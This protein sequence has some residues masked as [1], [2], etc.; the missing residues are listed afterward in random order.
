MAGGARIDLEVFVNCQ[1]GYHIRC[2]T[3]G[4]T[5]TVTLPDPPQVLVRSAGQERSAVLQDWKLRFNDA[6]DA[7]FVQWVQAVL[8]DELT[9]PSAWDGYA[10]AVIGDATITSLRTGEVVDIRLAD[11]PDCY[12]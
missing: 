9:G 5:G 12:A 2:E 11:R 3:V 4:E 10:A 7:E 8:D 6:F 1:Y